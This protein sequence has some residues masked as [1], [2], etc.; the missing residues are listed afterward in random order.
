MAIQDNIQAVN[1]EGQVGVNNDRTANS[2]RF[3][4]ES[5]TNAN[6][7][8]AELLG[9]I[10]QKEEALER[11]KKE[12]KND[13]ENGATYETIIDNNTPY[14]EKIAKLEEEI[15]ILGLTAG[16]MELVSNRAIKLIKKMYKEM[17]ASSNSIYANP[18]S[19]NE[20]LEVIPNESLEI[21]SNEENKVETAPIE[22]K[23]V[24]IV[25]NESLEVV[26]NESINAVS[27]IDVAKIS[28]DNG[29]AF[30]QS[31][32][33]AI[34]EE[35]TNDTYKTDE[36]VEVPAIEETTNNETMQVVTE[37]EIEQVTEPVVE[38]SF[39]HEPSEEEVAKI[40]ETEQFSMYQEINDE[41]EKIRKEVAEA[42]AAKDFTFTT[43]IEAK[44]EPVISEEPIITEVPIRDNIVIVPERDE[45]ADQRSI[46]MTSDEKAK[47]HEI[48]EKLNAARKK[49]EELMKEA[50]LVQSDMESQ[51][52]IDAEITAKQVETEKS[53]N[54]SIEVVEKTKQAYNDM[55]SSIQ[56]ELTAINNE[57]ATIQNDTQSKREELVIIRED[58]ISKTKKIDDLELEI[59]KNQDEKAKYDNLMEIVNDRNIVE[60][61]YDYQKVA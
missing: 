3:R 14:A 15:H 26:P 58:I 29:E 31:I 43:D 39:V 44:E 20:A 51:K 50:N 12:V 46:I 47:A 41:I 49:R 35:A 48:M 61:T 10:A 38:S 11:L 33:N 52:E 34:A 40:R 28:Q 22:D 36:V 21:V 57:N 18:V 55:I 54:E 5:V 45:L 1:I 60:E 27:D 16:P 4:Q 53:L 37:P 56:E 32:E 59:K 13:V 2:I 9:L 7:K 17:D 25:P 23:S 42:N 24:E 6:N 19:K 8:Y 30:G